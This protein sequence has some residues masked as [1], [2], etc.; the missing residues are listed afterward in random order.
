MKIRYQINFSYFSSN[1]IHFTVCLCYWYKRE[2]YFMALNVP[3]TCC[4]SRRVT[5]TFKDVEDAGAKVFIA[6]AAGGKGGPGQAVALRYWEIKRGQRPSLLPLRHCRCHI[7]LTIAKLLVCQP[8]IS[9]FFTSAP[10]YGGCQFG[11]P[12]S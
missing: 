4:N 12:I 1:N 10:N 5:I 6:T 9:L 8:C 11:A 2:K 7:I 3:H